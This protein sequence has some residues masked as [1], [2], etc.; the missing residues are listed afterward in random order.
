[1]NRQVTSDWDSGVQDRRVTFLSHLL[2]ATTV[3]GLVALVLTYVSLPEGMSVL[4]RG[5]EMAPFLVGWLVVLITWGWR[6]AGYRARTLIVLLLAYSLGVFILRR[7]GLPGSGRIWLLLLP[8]LTFVLVGLRAG[9]AAGVVSI[10][11]YAV[12]AL[13]F[14]QKWLVPLVT[15]DPAALRTWVSEG[16]SFLLIVV[17]LTLILWASSRSWLESLAGASAA[18]RQLQVQ[19]RELE[20]KNERLRRQTRELQVTAEIAQACS[21]ILDPE[22]LL[23]EVVDRIQEGFSLTGV[24]YVGLFLLDEEQ[25][26]AVLRAATGEAGQLLQEMDYKLELDETS[27]VGRCIARRQARIA[28]SG[29]EARVFGEDLVLVDA[30]LMP[31]TRSEVALPLRSRGR[32]LGALSVQ[33]TQETAFSEDDIAVMQTMA[34]QV[35]VAIDNARL[36]SQTEAVLEQVQAVQRRYLVQAWKEFLAARP[37]SRTDYTEPGAEPG[38]GDFLRKARREAVVQGQTV[39]VGN[40]SPDSN[41]QDSVPQ[42]ALVV[43]LKL[44]GQVIGTV[45]LHETRRQRPWTAEEIAMVETVAEQSALTVENLRLMDETQRRATRERMI[46]GITDRMWRATDMED[47]MRTTAEELNRALSG[48][49]AFVRLA[50]KNDEE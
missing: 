1:M 39:V 23:T 12:F 14:S 47:L 25:R 40:F 19:A 3:A 26:L 46:S 33:S 29:E 28:L 8:A 11:T 36:F 30:L 15:E 49:R 7:G 44:R 38:D 4:E 34:D 42:S 20:E 18:N 24:Y 41:E 32:V 5:I 9:L 43:P 50:M 10:F 13:A 48:S 22:K 21:S 17:S 37:V 45:A 31:H 35:A 16:G 6:G 2:L 27:A